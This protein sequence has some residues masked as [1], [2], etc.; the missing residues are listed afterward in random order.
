M[1]QMMMM[2][3]VLNNPVPKKVYIIILIDFWSHGRE[4]IHILIMNKFK[5]V[6]LKL[7]ILHMVHQE[8]LDQ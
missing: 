2:E 4:L 6:I 7:R 5:L 1:L 3:K 8:H